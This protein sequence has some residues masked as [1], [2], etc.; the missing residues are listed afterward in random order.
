MKKGLKKFLKFIK[1][2]TLGFIIGAIL[3]GSIGVYAAT[4]ASSSVVYDNT[5]SG[6]SATTV[7]E[8]IDDL[9]TISNEGKEK[10]ANAITDKG[11]STNK[12]DDFD[13]MAN[14]INLIETGVN[15]QTVIDNL[16]D[17]L[18]YS[19]MGINSNNSLSEIYD[20][21][22]TKFP[23]NLL[24][25]APFDTSAWVGEKGYEVNNNAN[26]AS[27]SIQSGKLVLYA[28]KSG[29]DAYASSAAHI[30]LKERIDLSPYKTLNIV[31]SLSSA[32]NT[33]TTTSFNVYINDNLV[34]S[35]GGTRQINDI[36]DI[37]SYGENSTIRFSAQG[38]QT[39]Q[40]ANTCSITATITKLYLSA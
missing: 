23:A 15:E 9:Y 5:N 22:K 1:T 25:G 21:L 20:A 39:W 16:V 8:A 38:Y 11:I 10:I 37:S 30:S 7:K 2:N 14:N 3:F 24:L 4:I 26:G 17:S 34:Y 19:G 31:A 6:S 12:E 33:N 40:T 28:T 29:Y 36:I 27:Y 32:I 35:S 18:K 13:T